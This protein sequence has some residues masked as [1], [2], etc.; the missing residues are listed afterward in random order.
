M[1]NGGKRAR[2][3]CPQVCGQT[4]QTPLGTHCIPEYPRGI[5]VPSETFWFLRA[6]LPDR[7]THA[8][9]DIE[10]VRKEH[11]EYRQVCLRIRMKLFHRVSVM[12]WSVA[13]KSDKSMIR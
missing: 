4:M 7:P 3:T 2:L 9:V 5:P 8:L 6:L 10:M 11:F 13:G 1:G 12:H